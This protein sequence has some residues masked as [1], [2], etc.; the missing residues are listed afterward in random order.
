MLFAFGLSSK[1][2]EVDYSCDSTDLGDISPVERRR[3]QRIINDLNSYASEIAEA[4][5]HP[6]QLRRL[7]IMNAI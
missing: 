4:N 7:K 5:F 6:S 3:K 1:I 2:K